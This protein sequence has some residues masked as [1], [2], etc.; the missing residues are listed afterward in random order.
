MTLTRRFLNSLLH[1]RLWRWVSLPLSYTLL[2]VPFFAPTFGQW[3]TAI[4]TRC[5][6]RCDTGWQNVWSLWWVAH[7]ISRG[8]SLTHTD[9]LFYPGGVELF[10]QT[11]MLANGIVMTP[12]TLLFGPIVA[13]NVL[14]Y[15][16][17]VASA[18]SAAVLA[19]AVVNHRY[20]AWV[21]GALY[22]CAPF[23]VWLSY[24]GFVE[25]VSIQYFP[26]LLLGLWY[27]SQSPH[28]RWA[29][30]T[31]VAVLGSFFSSLYY[32]LF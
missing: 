4:A 19:E 23:H 28:W 18:W 2:F 10:W 16:T 25:R 32:G 11:L 24:S 29:A 31:V 6:D 27:L 1:P 17:F 5:V 30:L 7:A 8:T 13:F 22:A 12:V 21:A 20:A 3:T 14:T 9:L 15:A 26:L